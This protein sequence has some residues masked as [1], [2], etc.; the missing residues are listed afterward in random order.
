MSHAL[1]FPLLHWAAG[2]RNKRKTLAPKALRFLQFE[3]LTVFFAT[4]FSY[5][6]VEK[7]RCK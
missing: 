3:T 4:R 2:R 5:Q 6:R 1:F 7:K